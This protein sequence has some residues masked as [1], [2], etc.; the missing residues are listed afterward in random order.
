MAAIISLFIWAALAQTTSILSESTQNAVAKFKQINPEWASEF[1]WFEQDCIDGKV[2]DKQCEWAVKD[3]LAMLE[4]EIKLQKREKKVN[5]R[6]SQVNAERAQVN[7]E[8]EMVNRTTIV[9]VIL[10]L[11]N[12][13]QHG[14]PDRS[15]MV[16]LD[17]IKNPI[18]QDDITFM[19]SIDTKLVQKKWISQQEIAKLQTILTN[20]AQ[21]TLRIYNSFTPKQQQEFIDTKTIAIWAQK[22]ALK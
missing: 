14:N 18:F 19:R 12:S 13:I 17:R 3:Q 9:T 1:V 10:Q 15:G 11:N 7:A 21:E 2:T 16:A 20:Q 4:D 22:Y 8:F 5:A 6:E